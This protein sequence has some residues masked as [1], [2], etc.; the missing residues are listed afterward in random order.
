[1][2]LLYST[3][4]IAVALVHVTNIMYVKMHFE[5]NTWVLAAKLSLVA[6]PLNYLL[7]IGFAYYYNQGSKMEISYAQ[8]LFF[9]MGL[10]VV[11]G[12]IVNQFIPGNP[13]STRLEWISMAIIL[14]GLALN[15]FAKHMK[16]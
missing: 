6:L 8:L 12:L 11:A 16:S 3:I 15:V 5:G 7:N 14:F 2:F 10:S 13:K 4:A 9:S 1:M